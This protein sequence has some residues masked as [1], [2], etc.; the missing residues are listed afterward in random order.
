MPRSAALLDRTK[1]RIFRL[2]GKEGAIRLDADADADDVERE[3]DEKTSEGLPWV[4]SGA[5]ADEEGYTSAHL[6]GEC[7][8]AALWNASCLVYLVCRSSS[9]SSAPPSNGF[10]YGLFALVVVPLAIG[11]S[12]G[13][14]ALWGTSRVDVARRAGGRV[15]MFGVW[16]ALVACI[17]SVYPILFHFIGGCKW[18]LQA[19][20][21]LTTVAVQVLLLKAGTD[22][23]SDSDSEDE[24]GPL[25]SNDLSTLLAPSAYD[26]EKTPTLLTVREMLLE[27]R[28]ARQHAV[29][30]E[31]E[32]EETL[33]EVVDEGEK[34]E[35]REVKREE[36]AELVRIHSFA[37]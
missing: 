12:A 15:R 26:S 33:V 6:L 35:M 24:Y 37:A 21:V 20:L 22:S 13:A 36:K 34:G 19:H 31:E 14:A 28:F 32:S 30:E 5:E 16:V 11:T 18:W 10:I 8:L 25:P 9:S 17:A 3:Y 7:I 29:V 23:F 4:L 27:A 1:T 2:L